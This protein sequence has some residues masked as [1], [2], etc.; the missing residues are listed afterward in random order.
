LNHGRTLWR[1]FEHTHELIRG[2]ILALE[3]ATVPWSHVALQA[4]IV[5]ASLAVVAQ[6][7]HYEHE[8]S[9]TKDATECDDGDYVGTMH[10]NVWTVVGGR[11]VV[12]RAGLHNGGR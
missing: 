7:E 6:E 5:L 12:C 8:D 4:F 11:R 9:Y 2:L 3:R 1:L 10:S